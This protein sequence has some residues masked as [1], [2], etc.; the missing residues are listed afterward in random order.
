MSLKVQVDE[1][2]IFAPSLTITNNLSNHVS[3]FGSGGGVTFG[4]SFSLPLAVSGSSKATRTETNSFYFRFAD[5]KS[6]AELEWK[7]EAAAANLA[8]DPSVRAAKRTAFLARPCP[9]SGGVMM[10]GDLKIEDFIAT[11]ILTGSVPGVISRTD[12]TPPF[13]AFG[14]EITFV[15]T[16]GGSVSPSW[17]L[18]PIS[19]NQNAPLF[20]GSRVRTNDMILTLGKVDPDTNKPA[21]AADDVH[22]A[23]L[24]GQAVA[25]ALSKA[26]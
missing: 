22:Q 8:Y 9:A 7:A 6:D 20:V 3:S 2:A 24:I 18:Y 25:E 26:P 16:Q 5:L 19:I 23:A 14:Y 10:E 12:G 1:S 11:K 17:R 21:K 15:V 13:D 4:Q